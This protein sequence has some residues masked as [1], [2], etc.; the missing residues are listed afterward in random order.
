M[1]KAH[2]IEYLGW[3]FFGLVLIAAVPAAIYT[4]YQITSDTVTVGSRVGMGIALAFFFTAFFT[5]AANGL[6]QMWD[7]RMD[8]DGGTDTGSPE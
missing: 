8:G 5:W 4:M 1:T 6:L 3:G 7:R 2:R